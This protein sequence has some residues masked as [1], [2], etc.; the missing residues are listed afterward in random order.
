M[1]SSWSTSQGRCNDTQR[2]SGCES[3]QRSQSVQASL[4]PVS[5]QS[6]RACTRSSESFLTIVSA[7]ANGRETPDVVGGVV[8]GGS[9]GMLM[10]LLGAATVASTGDGGGGSTGAGDGGGVASRWGLKMP[11]RK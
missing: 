2:H 9:K 6:G 7:D 8:V 3:S 1:T 10:S 4:P 5:V 11:G